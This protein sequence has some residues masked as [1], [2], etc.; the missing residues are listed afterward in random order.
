MAEI[1]NSLEQFKERTQ[2]VGEQI[3]NQ[4]AIEDPKL[5][6]V[7][8]EHILIHWDE[9]VACLLDE[10]IAEEVVELNRVEDVRMKRHHNTQ[11]AD[12]SLVGKFHDYKSVDLREITRIF[13]DYDQAERAIRH[14][15]E[16]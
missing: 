5:L 10:L 7:I 8:M 16:L 3:K 1:I 2:A 12:R 4:Y 14:F 15:T 11:L 13:D 6:A 9:I